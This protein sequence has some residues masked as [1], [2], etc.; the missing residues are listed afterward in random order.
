MSVGHLGPEAGQN[1]PHL[2]RGRRERTR[3]QNRRQQ[4]SF[5]VTLFSQICVFTAGEEFMFPRKICFRKFPQ[6]EDDAGVK[7]TVGVDDTGADDS[8]NS[9]LT[10]M[11]H[12]WRC[13]YVCHTRTHTHTHT[14]GSC[15]CHLHCI[16]SV[17]HRGKAGPEKKVYEL[18]V[19]FYS[20]INPSVSE[21][22]TQ[23]PQV[24]TSKI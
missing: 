24:V 11:G 7:Y 16:S 20:D 22:G 1:L 2:Q 8:W 13:L 21:V 18:T 17:C 12:A 3:N 9:S 15:C 10:K 23:N 4:T 14:Q 19:E 6:R 5:Q